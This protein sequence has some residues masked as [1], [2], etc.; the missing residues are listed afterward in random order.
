MNENGQQ[1]AQQQISLELVQREIGARALE[2][3]LLHQRVVEL[4]TENT[5]LQTALAKATMELSEVK[6]L[7]QAQVPAGVSPEFR[8]LAG[9]H[10]QDP[11]APLR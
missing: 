7:V 11:L 3:A 10:Q 2:I 6:S 4:E 8:L 5:A 9:T 1:P